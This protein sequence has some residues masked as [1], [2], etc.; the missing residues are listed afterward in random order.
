M[1]RSSLQTSAIGALVAAA[2]L[3]VVA[4]P[5]TTA[6][7]SPSSAAAPGQPAPPPR[8]GALP[9]QLTPAQQK[10]LLTRAGADRAATARAIG[11]SGKEQL[12]PRSV[13]KDAD[14][15]VHTRYERTFDG[16]PV[17]GG[18]LVVHS[19]AS[20]AVKSVT[21]A[22]QA[23]ITVPSTT[24]VRSA[25]SATRSS[26][27]RAKGFGIAKTAPAGA[28]RA[29]VWAGTGRPVLAWETVINGIQ[30]DGAPSELHVITHGTT[31]AEL[32][33]YDGVR[34]GTGHSQH[35]GPVTVG[36]SR[37][38]SFFNLTDNGRGSHR[39][40]DLN[41]KWGW[42]A[43]GTVL[44]DT[45]DVWGDGT[46][47]NRQTDGVD[48][49]YGAQVTWDY[50]AEKHNRYGL[51]NDGDGGT[52]R[53]HYGT[54]YRSA[55]WQDSCFC[56]THGDGGTA[57]HTSLDVTAHEWAHGLTAQTAKLYYF[58]EAGG[59]AEASSDIFA[60]AVEFHADNDHDP[61]DY[62]IKEKV[63]TAGW[64]WM[65]RN[66]DRP[67]KTAMHTDYWHPRIDSGR[68]DWYM[69]GPAN[70]WFYLLSEGSGAKTVNG[71]QYD[72]PTH[73]GLP[74]ARIGRAAAERIWY[75]ALTVYMTS[76]TNYAGART[77][78][79]AAAA[80]LYGVGSTVHKRVTDAWG[81]VNV[82]QRSGN[83]TPRPP[84]PEFE[85]IT[86]HPL[87]GTPA[88]AVSSITV[89]GVPGNAP[90]ILTIDTNVML[91]STADLELIA[92]D[93]TVYPIA[94]AYGGIEG[95]NLYQGTVAVDASAEVANGTWKLRATKGPY[96]GAAGY[97]DSWKL[98]F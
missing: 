69:A 31:G 14:G 60:T 36:S 1:R 72:S 44:T 15:T 97:I 84:G 83:P 39:T 22:T 95:P 56:V 73:D 90:N 23:R 37:F 63:D 94:G 3:L 93:G 62:I 34:K 46:A 71:V 7:A 42:D 32:H 11:L 21:R 96:E 70:H 86:D 54:D 51:R 33:R 89:S 91:A 10:G 82:G 81:A 59:L 52:S 50:F 80:D 85:N 78:T 49:A 48:A 18:D 92:P 58:G 61:G 57:P 28:P 87:T 98:Y 5:S 68:R 8:A 16:I 17:L 79:L 13:L 47:S 12:V 40:L 9:A 27:A 41:G 30:D 45:D 75:R 25:A 74:V 6:G 43:V 55:F 19:S 88:Q 26:L 2:S 77:A 76:T 29:V 66:M 24:P 64:P 65:V 35:S 38:G 67:S 20:G 53:I 4:L